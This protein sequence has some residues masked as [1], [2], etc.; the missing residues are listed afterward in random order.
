MSKHK[1]S[2]AHIAAMKRR[3]ADPTSRAALVKSMIGMQRGAAVPE[4]ASR[5]GKQ[6]ARR[7]KQDPE[8][9]AAFLERQRAANAARWADHEKT[10][11][12]CVICGDPVTK[13][14]RETC[15]KPG[16]IA[17][18]KAES[19]RARKGEKRPAMSDAAKRR[20]ASA[21]RTHWEKPEYR[22]KVVTRA[23]AASRTPENRAKRSA[24]TKARWSDPIKAE[25][26]V[27]K[28]VKNS[29]HGRY[30]YE[31]RLGR[32]FVFKSGDDWERGFA[33]WL[34]SKGLDWDYEPKVLR[35]SDGHRYIPDFWVAEWRTFI[36]L[37]ATHRDTL[38]AEQA[39]REGWP[40]VILQG[41]IAILTFQAAK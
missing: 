27:A 4:V 28:V 32:R 3:W 24:A 5:V 38:K 29:H 15:G 11:P 35:L 7:W 23:T 41:R 30:P 10:Y 13:R 39:Q 36:E 31:C 1:G 18:R 22:D 40:M 6:R 20:I 8:K 33:R 34:D 21:S 9:Y 37:K 26:W 16:C 2:P 14:Q 25:A 12:P 17:V 19:G